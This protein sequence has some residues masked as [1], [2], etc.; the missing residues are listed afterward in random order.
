ML[1]GGLGLAVAGAAGL[2]RPGIALPQED[3]LGVPGL[4]GVPGAPGQTLAVPQPTWYTRAQWGARP[5][6]GTVTVLNSRP[7][8]VIVHHTAG[9]NTTNY[10][11]SWAF[12]LSRGIQNYHMDSNGWVDAGQQ[13]TISRGGYIMEGRYRSI[14]ALTSGTKHVVGA[15]VAN[16]N[17]SAIGIENEGTYITASPT[18]ALW[19]SL[20]NTVAYM[21]QQYAISPSRIFGHRDYNN[22]QCPGDRL[23]AMLPQLRDEVAAK[24]G[25]TNPPDPV[26]WPLVRQGDSGDRVRTVQ[27]LLRQHGATVTVDGQFG[28]ATDSAVRSFQTSRGLVSDGLVGGQTWPVLVVTVRNGSTGEAVRGAQVQLRRHGSTITVDGQFGPAT[29]TAVRSF[30]SSK[31]LT[32]D[33]VVGPVTW[34]NLVG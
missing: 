17:S 6:S 31:A 14:E 15:H 13:F 8:M 28:P 26:T 10:S 1:R 19:N 12:Q 20:V 33:G 23:Y 24:L 30:Q 18:T 5:P 11:Q 2:I 16:Y 34:Q 9:G 21:C 29:E 25:G 32:V 22:T 4:D 7:T 3:L 27:H